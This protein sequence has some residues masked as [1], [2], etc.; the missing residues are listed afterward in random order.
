MSVRSLLRCKNTADVYVF[1]CTLQPGCIIH[2]FQELLLGDPL[3]FLTYTIRSCANRDN[4]MSF[5]SVCLWFPSCALLLW[6]A[7]PTLYRIG[8]KDRG[9]ALLPFAGETV[10][11]PTIKYVCCTLFLWL[12]FIRLREFSYMAIFFKTF[13]HAW[14]Q[15]IVKYIFLLIDMIMW[16]FVFNL[17][18]W[19][20]TSVNFQILNCLIFLE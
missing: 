2:W 3:G 11:L 7:L 18:I 4:F 5:W 15:D 9:P 8:Y 1:T 12:L 17:W 19:W 13:Y 20:I 16:M 10:H 14:E 6:L